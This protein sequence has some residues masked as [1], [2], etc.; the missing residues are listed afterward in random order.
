MNLKSKSSEPRCEMLRNA[1]SLAAATVALAAVRR[2]SRARRGP[3]GDESSARGRRADG[4]HG[5]DR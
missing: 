1:K 4:I 3:G 2:A 5:S